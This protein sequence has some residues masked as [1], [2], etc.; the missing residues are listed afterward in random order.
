VNANVQ[1][2][3]QAISDEHG[4]VVSGARD[5]VQRGL[6]VIEFACG[7]ATLLKGGF[8][9]QVS[10]GVDVYSF[11]QPPGVCVGITPFN[12]PAMVPMWMYPLAI[13]TGNTVILKPS[14]RD[15]SVS[16]LIAELWSEAGLP[17]G[18][19]NVVHGDKTAVDALLTHPDVAAVASPSSC[20]ASPGRIR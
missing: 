5:E 10:A 15:P 18:V 3:A 4:K 11:R 19:F 20:R 1:R 13:A 16:M 14:E 17:D 12:F 2:L 9:D 8:S 6:E 7:I